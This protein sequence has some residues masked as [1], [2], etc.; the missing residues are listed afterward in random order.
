MGQYCHRLDV[1]PA[2]RAG[3]S[4]GQKKR[5]LARK[6]LGVTGARKFS[7]ANKLLTGSGALPD[8]LAAAG[9]SL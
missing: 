4:A 3:M 6:K 9:D 8:K 2:F 5:R 1:V 7:L